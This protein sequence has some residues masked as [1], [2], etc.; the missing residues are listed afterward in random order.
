[1]RISSDAKSQ[2]QAID[3]SHHDGTL[4]PGEPVTPLQPAAPG[5]T[6]PG[7]P[8]SAKPKPSCAVTLSRTRIVV[9]K[10]T[11]VRAH[12]GLRKVILTVRS[13]GKGIARARTSKAGSAR[14]TIRAPLTVPVTVGVACH[15][16]CS[17]ARLQVVAH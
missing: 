13:R 3:E 9:R 8:G 10:R 11:V 5:T 12:V 15:A 14:L 7:P 1:V 2:D 16:T 4:T 6:L 17:A